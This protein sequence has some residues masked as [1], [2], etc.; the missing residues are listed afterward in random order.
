MLSKNLQNLS[1][2][3]LV[4]FLRALQGVEG[5]VRYWL[6]FNVLCSKLVVA[7]GSKN[8]NANVPGF[9]GKA[10][11]IPCFHNG[12]LATPQ[13]LIPRKTVDHA[14]KKK[15]KTEG[16]AIPKPIEENVSDQPSKL[17]R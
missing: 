17:S 8:V 16:V 4:E 3:G 12:K 6:H 7:L 9:T 13:S 5:Q 10:G 15:D 1:R 2:N 11:Q 14:P